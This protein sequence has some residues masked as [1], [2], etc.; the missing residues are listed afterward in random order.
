MSRSCLIAIIR[1][2]PRF[3]PSPHRLPLCPRPT[4]CRRR[5]NQRRAR[6]DRAE[7][8]RRRPRIPPQVLTCRRCLNDRTINAPDPPSRCFRLTVPQHM[9]RRLQ[10]GLRPELDRP[11]LPRRAPRSRRAARRV[12]PDLSRRPL[13]L[14]TEPHPLG[15][16]LPREPASLPTPEREHRT[17]HR[18]RPPK[19]L[20]KAVP[21][22][23]D[24]ALSLSRD[25]SCLTGT[26]SEADTSHRKGDL[27]E[28]PGSN[29]HSTQQWASGLPKREHST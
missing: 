10:S 18:R 8:P 4:R 19:T 21:P 12:V 29:A 15:G 17:L 25:L 22:D 27:V 5:V 11:Y 23:G 6:P 24:E 28:P 1:W 3:R 9:S 7:T 13:A 20:N 2:K 16:S 26:G 14:T